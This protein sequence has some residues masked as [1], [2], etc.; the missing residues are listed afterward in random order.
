MH[1]FRWVFQISLIQSW[2]MV[3]AA[4]RLVVIVLQQQGGRLNSMI[5]GEKSR[6]SLA[7]TAAM[8]RTGVVI[9]ALL[10]MVGAAGQAAA[11]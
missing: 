9:S 5:S 11:G 6:Q 1:C 8:A 4:F 3:H 7:P 2:F 10:S